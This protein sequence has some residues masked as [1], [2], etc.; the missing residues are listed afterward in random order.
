M[1]IKKLFEKNKP[2][3]VLSSAS[4]S[5]EGKNAES[6]RFIRE[7]IKDVHRFEPHI[8]FSTAS[9]FVK[10]GSAEKYYTDAIR[11]IY[12]EYPYDGA[13]SEKQRFYNSSSYLDTYFFEN[14]YPRTNGFII[15]SADGWGALAGGSSV[16]HGYGLPASAE[17]I[18]VKGGPHT[19]SVGMVGKPLYK[20]FGNANVYETSSQRHSNLNYDATTGS[21]V[22]FWLRKD[23]WNFNVASKEVVFDLWNGDESGSVSYGRLRIEMTGAAPLSGT[24][25]LTALSGTSGAYS[26]PIGTSVTTASLTN[27]H[28]YAFSVKNSSSNLEIKFYQDGTLLETIVTGTSMNKVTGS[29]IGRIGALQTHVSGADF[30][31]ATSPAAGWGKL[32]ASLDEFRFW[33]S[34]RTSEDVGKNW[35][36]QVNG[37]VNSDDANV[38]LGVYFKFNEGITLTA[39][40]DA[41]VLD[42]SGRVSNGRWVGYVGS[43]SRDTGSAMILSSA[44]IGEFKDPIIYE[45]HPDVKSLYYDY[46][47]SGSY[48]D[49]SNNASLLNSLPGWIIDDEEKNGHGHLSQ[50]TQIISSYF[51]TLHSQISAVPSLPDVKYASASYKPIPFARQFLES[52]GL[53]TSEIF[54]DSSIT[55]RL[56]AK[57]DDMDFGRELDEIKNLIYINI[58]NNLVNIYKSKGTEDSF[59]N[60]IRCYGVDDEL[61]KLRLY[62]KNNRFTLSNN[63]SN[64]YTKKRTIDFNHPD[65][66]ESVVYQYPEAGNANSTGFISGSGDFDYESN[67]PVTVEVNVLFPSRYKE[68]DPFFFSTQ[69]QSSSLFGIHQANTGSDT[70]LDWLSTPND[71]GSVQVFVVKDDVESPN[72][73]FQLSSSTFNVDITSSIYKNLYDNGKWSLALRLRPKDYPVGGITSQTDDDDY[74]LELYGVKMYGDTI[75]EEF[76]LSSSVGYTSSLD[77]LSVAKRMYVGA[78]R[79]NTTGATKQSSDIRVSSA[80]YWFSYLSDDEI[81]AHSRDPRNFGVSRPQENAYLLKSNLSGN[82]I[83][84]MSTLALNWDFELVTGSGDS[85]DGS[86]TTSDAKF[87][88]VDISSGSSAHSDRYGWISN[89]LN[90]QH[91][92]RGDNFLPDQTNVIKTEYIYTN[93]QEPPDVGTTSDLITI[94]TGTEEFFTRESR[95]INHFFMFEKSMQNVISDEMLKFFNGIVDF[96]NIIGEPVNRYR[97]EYK[98]LRILRQMFFERMDNTPDIDKFIEYYKWIDNSLSIFLEQL[99]PAGSNFGEGIRNIV[100]SHVLERNKIDYKFPTMEFNVPDPETP[101]L[102]IRE[103]K[104]NWKY[105]HHP[106]PIGGVEQT[107]SNCQWWKERASGSAAGSTS[108]DA[109]VDRQRDQIDVVLTTHYSRSAA[110]FATPAKVTYSGSTYVLRNLDRPYDFVVD[111]SKV[112]KGGVNYDKAK[113]LSLIYNF[114]NPHGPVSSIGLPLNIITVGLVGNSTASV[115]KTIIQRD[116]KDDIIPNQKEKLEISVTTARTYDGKGDYDDHLK[117]GIALPFSIF[118]SSVFSGYSKGLMQN[119]QTGAN[120]V[121]VHNDAYAPHNE[122]PMQGP[123][124][125]KYV[126]GHQSRHIKLNDGTDGQTTRPEAWRIVFGGGPGGDPG[127]FGVVGADYGGP[128]PDKTRLRATRFREEY[129]KRPVNIKNI[130]QTTGSSPTKIGNYTKTYEIVSIFGRSNNSIEFVRN[131][132]AALPTGVDFLPAT[133]NLHTMVAVGASISGNYFGRN[134]DDV[135]NVSNR[136]PLSTNKSISNYSSSKAIIACQF[137]APGGPEIQSLGYLDLKSQEFSVYNALPFRNLSVRSSA[138]GEANT[139]RVESALGK[140]EGLI[141]VLSRHSGKFGIDSEYGSVVPTSYS[142]T[143]SFHKIPR[144]ILRRVEYSSPSSSYV[145]YTASFDNYW[146]QHTLP[147]SDFQY[148]WLTASLGSKALDPDKYSSG[149]FIGYIPRSGLVISGTTEVSA[150]NFPTISDISV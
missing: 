10:Y 38:D 74:T 77:F 34:V 44:S 81:K 35:W 62:T 111:E 121:N 50:L 67:L 129:A 28:H 3:K 5:E 36:T 32:S 127:A 83:P 117:G 20:T 144:N 51:D 12:E 107:G 69:F 142:S 146:V 140:R 23:D 42:Y 76:S 104:Y 11:R 45:F 61:I 6:E 13:L 40:V 128:Y 26:V 100:E 103:L 53:T 75:E 122:V 87:T 125:E 16:T 85:S 101:I 63:Y 79:Q 88:V 71:S 19:A 84:K 18:N 147:R 47:E 131:G 15:F 7:K 57:N 46:K 114:T 48:F 33:K 27:W 109:V 89:V 91:T 133:T 70:D 106:I 150:V 80:R 115:A 21:T 145:T 14:K 98:D 138:S 120:I 123:F 143:P 126:G 54:P 95:P 92:G 43:N 1:S 78:H 136:F 66:F 93:R 68:S 102:G 41:T 137:S 105:N 9:N 49:Y 119:F 29:L 64:T 148:A 55:E 96:N 56:L 17:Y 39:S 90:K 141:T 22:E 82:Y 86:P 60:M 149:S 124:T 132:G 108:G 99:V 94:V 130:K 31:F 25:M 110:I 58:Y 73:H 59:R 135:T 139:I 72:A 30:S 118:S 2:Y 4:L 65:R 24:F 97:Q 52:K 134:N 112:I 8:D 116:C 113:S 37:G